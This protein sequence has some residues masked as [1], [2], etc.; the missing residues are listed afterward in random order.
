MK[1]S[2]EKGLVLGDSPSNV[3]PLKI[4]NRHLLYTSVIP[5][6]GT[7]FSKECRFVVFLKNTKSNYCVF[8]LNRNFMNEMSPKYTKQE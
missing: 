7:T 3:D 5:F 1:T 2:G 6:R 4:P 8:N